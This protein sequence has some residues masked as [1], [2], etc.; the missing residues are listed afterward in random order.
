MQQL[1]K[2]LLRFLDKENI[3]V[4]SSIFF[5]PELSLNVGNYTKLNQLLE[6]MKSI[7][8]GL[9]YFNQLN[10]LDHVQALVVKMKKF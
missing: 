7:K 10:N 8:K 5:N 3:K 4:I 2:Q 1:L 9:Y 6:D